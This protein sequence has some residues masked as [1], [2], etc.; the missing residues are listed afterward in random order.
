MRLQIKP[1]DRILVVSPHPDDESIG[2]GGLIAL[3]HD[4]VDVLLVTDGYNA[5]LDNRDA[6]QLRQKEFIAA[7]ETAQ[8]HSYS[9]LHIP[10]HEIL[11][12][13]EKFREVD[14]SQYTHVFVPNRHEE[15]RDHVAVFKTVKSRVG[16]HT[17]LYEYEVWTTIRKPNVLL[18][19]AQVQEQKQD[20]I[21][22]HASQIK[23]LDY[24]ALA[25]GLN[26]YRGLT[27]GLKYAE[28][29]DCRAE[30]YAERIRHLKKRLRA[31]LGRG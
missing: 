23:E 19:I 22:C 7:M 15:H 13:R 10:E 12:N 20:M 25:A 16:K 9:M 26:A 1:K 29:Y 3:Y 14:F 6:S 17:R 18:D 4:Q 30:R 28:S 11:H 8:V 27:H 5:A 21:L 2:C 24:C 31:L